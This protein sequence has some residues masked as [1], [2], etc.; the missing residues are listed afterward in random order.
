MKKIP[1]QT[2]CFKVAECVNI[3]QLFFSINIFSKLTPFHH[4][5]IHN[6]KNDCN[7]SPNDTMLL[8]FFSFH[9]VHV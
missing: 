6:H 4:Y 8:Q 3:L 9:H 7:H 5:N 2:I 1:S